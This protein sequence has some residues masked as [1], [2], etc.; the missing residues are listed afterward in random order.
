MTVEDHPVHEKTRIEA[1]KPYGCSTDKSPNESA[2]G[3][4]TKTRRFLPDGRFVLVDYFIENKMSKD[5]RSFYLWDIDP[6]CA[7]CTRQRDAEY[8]ELMKGLT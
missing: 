1:G 4:W 2:K 8:A 6:R 7:I 5:C 3:Y